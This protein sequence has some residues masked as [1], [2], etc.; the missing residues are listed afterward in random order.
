[1]EEI[2]DKKERIKILRGEGLSYNKIAETVGISKQYVGQVLSSKGQVNSSKRSSK[3]Q[4]DNK[5]PDTVEQNESLAELKTK[6]NN[7]LLDIYDKLKFSDLRLKVLK[8]EMIEEFNKRLNRVV[9]HGLKLAVEG[10][11]EEII[12]QVSR[13]LKHQ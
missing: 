6:I 4:V 7:I 11:R 2:S 9:S 3:G 8:E 12:Q 1:M 13:E 10:M 5:K